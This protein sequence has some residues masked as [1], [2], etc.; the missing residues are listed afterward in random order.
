MSV[1]Y[2]GTSMAPFSAVLPHAAGPVALF[3]IFLKKNNTVSA[4]PLPTVMVA[5]AAGWPP[6]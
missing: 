3:Y 2:V 6:R 1:N 5:M 4:T